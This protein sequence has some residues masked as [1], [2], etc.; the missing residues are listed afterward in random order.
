ME[1][2]RPFR[3]NG[4]VMN[5]GLITNLPNGCCVE[6]PCMV[7]ARGVQPVV[8]GELPPQLAALNR[9]NINVQDLVIE[10]SLTGDIDAIYHAVALDPLAGTTCT[11]PQ[12]RAMVDEL[13][14]AQAE[15]LTQFD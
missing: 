1:T 2:N 11:L 3:I 4:N 14:T 8:V 5:E 13:M 12:I 10:A 9:T 6:V 15:W 7:D